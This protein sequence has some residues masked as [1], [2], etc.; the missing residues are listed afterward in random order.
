M[1][2]GNQYTMKTN[3]T[4]P[5]PPRAQT[6]QYLIV[7]TRN[8]LSGLSIQLRESLYNYK[9]A[10]V[11]IKVTTPTIASSNVVRQLNWN[12]QRNIYMYLIPLQIPW[13]YTFRCTTII[14]LTVNTVQEPAVC[15]EEPTRR[16]KHLSTKGTFGQEDI[17]LRT[18]PDTFVLFDVV[19][20]H[21][22]Q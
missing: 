9:R 1:T 7:Y 22:R 18:N 15:M 6:S 13:V 20:G 11:Q 4:T 3:Q 19:Q 12:T 17:P 14:L 8:L 21:Q 2:N 10:N 16:G 5:P